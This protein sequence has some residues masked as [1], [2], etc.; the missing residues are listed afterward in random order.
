[1]GTPADLVSQFQN[2]GPKVVLKTTEG[3]I[4]LTF[5]HM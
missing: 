2:H 5:S 4:I 3:E 1:M